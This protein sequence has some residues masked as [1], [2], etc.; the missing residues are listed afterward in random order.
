MISV[1]TI[2][3][4]GLHLAG[5]ALAGVG[6]LSAVEWGSGYVS[7]GSIQNEI[8]HELRTIGRSIDLS[9]WEFSASFAVEGLEVFDDSYTIDARWIQRGSVSSQSDLGMYWGLG[10]GLT[11]Q[12][13]SGSTLDGDHY[14]LTARY[15]LGLQYALTD[16]MHLQFG[17]WAGIGVG[18]LTTSGIFEDE[19]FSSVVDGGLVLD[20]Y[21]GSETLLLHA[22][23]A[24]DLST[25][26]YGLD[27]SGGSI[28]LN[29]D[30]DYISPRVGLGFAF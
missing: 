22:G 11:Y 14:A 5:F 26:N 6:S 18:Y 9:A 29:L 15:H 10:L 27:G 21:F 24:Y 1:R 13:F 23:I 19:D 7:D 16:W 28:S 17:G 25:A 2:R 12:T 30:Q 4:T 20:W 8:A 3:H